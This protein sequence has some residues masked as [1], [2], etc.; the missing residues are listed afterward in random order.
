MLKFFCSH[1][2]LCSCLV[3]LLLL[4]LW[5]SH[6]VLVVDGDDVTCWMIAVSCHCF[7]RFMLLCLS[8]VVIL[9]SHVVVLRVRILLDVVDV[10]C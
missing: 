3:L 5:Q 4:L 1:L 7:S 2:L 6:V 9:Q 8:Q 10:S